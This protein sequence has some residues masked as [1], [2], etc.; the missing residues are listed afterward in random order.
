[1]SVVLSEVRSVTAVSALLAEAH[2]SGRLHNRLI[3]RR[4]SATSVIADD[5]AS[6]V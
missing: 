1:M 3:A 6:L 2:M 4:D 5:N